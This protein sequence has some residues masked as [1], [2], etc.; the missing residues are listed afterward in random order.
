MA[1]SLPAY[2]TFSYHSDSCKQYTFLRE[3]QSA[4]QSSHLEGQPCAEHE[5]QHKFKVLVDGP[6]RLHSPISVC[7][8]EV[9]GGRRQNLIRE[10]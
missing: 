9:Q 10:E 6:E 5:H 8:K 1:P 3:R 2:S 7:D 4:R